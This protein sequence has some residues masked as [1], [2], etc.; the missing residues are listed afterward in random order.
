MYD[1]D[2]FSNDLK[3]TATSTANAIKTG[4]QIIEFL[5]NKDPEQIAALAVNDPSFQFT[6]QVTD[7]QFFQTHAVMSM[8]MVTN[9]QADSLRV[10]VQDEFNRAARNGLIQIDP[11]QRT[12]TPTEKGMKYISQPSFK[13]AARKYAAAMQNHQQAGQNLGYPLNGGINDLNYFR[14]ANALDLSEVLNSS[15]TEAAAKVL[16]GFQKLQAEGKV[17]ISGL[18]VTL[19]DA[20]KKYLASP[21]MQQAAQ[22]IKPVPLGSPVAT[23]V[24]VAIQNA[25]QIAQRLM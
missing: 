17:A 5:Q 11:V 19:T 8:D 15:N 18:T 24:V 12:I 2:E 9:I 4:Y 23:A 20:G 3:G 22:A 25:R 21:V 16:S 6:G 13:Q 10:A 14:Y 7:L 1:A